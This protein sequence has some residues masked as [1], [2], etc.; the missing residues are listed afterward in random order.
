MQVEDCPTGKLWVD[1]QRAL[2]D[3]PT[4]VRPGIHRVACGDPSDLDEVFVEEGTVL[5]FSPKR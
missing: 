3:A 1:G 4:P 2:A 5:Y